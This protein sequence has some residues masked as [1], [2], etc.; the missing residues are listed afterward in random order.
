MM[1]EWM[2]EMEDAKSINRAVDSVLQQGIVTPD[3][4]GSYSTVDVSDAIAK[5]VSRQRA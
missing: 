3:L 5:M 1:L 2:G 4:G